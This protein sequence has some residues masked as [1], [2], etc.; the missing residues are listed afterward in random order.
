M[1]TQ[2][3]IIVVDLGFGDSGKG[4]ITDF[5]TRT[6]N[7]KTIVRFNGGAQAAHNVIT[8]D[9]RHHTFA[10]FGSGMFVLGV[11][12]YLSRYML[13]D[14]Y[15]M[16]NEEEHLRAVG[17]DTA[18]SRMFIHRQALIITPFQQ[19]ANRL[20]ELSRGTNRHGSCGM[21]IGETMA[22]YLAY[23]DQAIYAG[24][25]VDPA[26]VKQKLQFIRELKQRELSDVFKIVED[27]DAA[28]PDVNVFTSP[29][30]IDIAAE[31][32]AYLASQIT[33]VDNFKFGTVIFEAAQGVLLDEWYGFS[34]YTTWSTTTFQ[35][36]ET[37]LRESGYSDRVIRLGVLR[38]YFTRHGAGPFVTE[39]SALNLPELHNTNSAWQQA[40]R[41]GYFDLIAARYA[42]AVSG[43]VDALAIT[44]LDYLECLPAW[45]L[46]QAYEYD[47]SPD[48]LETFF[49]HD[50]NRI[51]AIKVHH[52]A[53]L[54]HQE[55]LTQLLFR[56][57]P[58]YRVIDHHSDY[59]AELEKALGV[60]IWITSG[61]PT[62]ADK[63]I[64][65][66]VLAE[67]V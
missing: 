14:P 62:A 53:D 12:T 32:Y 7:A 36:A 63:Q 10:Q 59:C 66:H 34:P 28:Q 6:Y 18:F 29:D 27:L 15:A 51:S 20:K 5:L 67:F 54:A 3:A 65:P 48:D 21:G 42:L 22:D 4:T 44:H 19:A 11:Q 40:F 23:P 52:P 38:S 37:L 46:C 49:E 25:L 50:G 9:G 61:G 55:R 30:L 13:I 16:F 2:Q 45:K 41:V 24:D 58:V 39:D 43:S 56:C 17:V 1:S 60:P 8:P 64:I 31:N 33:L 47:G 35:N 26:T 57:K